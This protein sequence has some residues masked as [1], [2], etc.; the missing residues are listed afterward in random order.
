MLKGSVTNVKVKTT[1]KKTGSKSAPITIESA[2]EDTQDGA[3]DDAA[4]IISGNEDDKG[5]VVSA[6]LEEDICYECGLSTLNS[7]SWNDVI[8]CDLCD[9]EYH[10]HCQQLTVAPTG[11][12]VCLMRNITKTSNLKCQKASR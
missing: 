11:S 2:T 3:S 1:K 6:I 5:S 4:S 9:S 10:L 7:D 12:W 8:M